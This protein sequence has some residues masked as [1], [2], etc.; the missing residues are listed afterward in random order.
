MGAPS[1]KEITD[2]VKTAFTGGAVAFLMTTLLLIVS[3]FAGSIWASSIAA[4]PATLVFFAVAASIFPSQRTETNF[5]RFLL[6]STALYF[7]LSIGV[8]VWYLVSLK[9]NI[10]SRDWRERT[11]IG[12]GASITIWVV[13]VIV[14][15]TLYYTNQTWHDYFNPNS[16][17]EPEVATALPPL[18]PG[19]LSAPPQ[20]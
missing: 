4:F 19:F 2:G 16:E 13:V 5:D 15:L 8:L 11:W 1:K 12:F 7:V 3:I 20:T 10:S 18:P 9:S 6:L 14:L 17:P